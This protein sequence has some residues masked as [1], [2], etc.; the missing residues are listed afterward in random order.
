MVVFGV[1]TL[2]ILVKRRYPYL[3]H[4]YVREEIQ[5]VGENEA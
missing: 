2:R 1:R 5:S 3:L 4:L